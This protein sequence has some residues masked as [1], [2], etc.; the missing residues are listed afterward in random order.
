MCKLHHSTELLI[1]LIAGSIEVSKGRFA[2]E[3]A[4]SPTTTTQPLAFCHN[5]VKKMFV[6]CSEL[7]T[8]KITP[9]PAY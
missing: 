7:A 2:M 5:A 3:I 8:T 9:V 6:K 1:K 4:P